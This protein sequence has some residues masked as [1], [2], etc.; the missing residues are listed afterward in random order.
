MESTS[1]KSKP[2]DMKTSAPSPDPWM[3]GLWKILSCACFAAI[4]GMVRYLSGGVPHL[5]IDPLPFYEIAFLQN[6]IGALFMLPW[7]F[8]VSGGTFRTTMPG[9]HILR[10]LFA[11]TGLLLWYGALHVMPLAQ[12]VAL[13]FTGPIFSIIGCRLFLKEAL[14]LP[15][16]S[17]IL[18]SLIGGFVITRP[19]QALL[20]GNGLIA[21]IGVLACL[22]LFAAIAWVGSKLVA[23]HMA[24]QGESASL[25]T[26]YLLL[27]M[28]PIS[29]IPAL[30]VWQTPSLEQMGWVTA[31]GITAS[32]AHL[33]LAR[34][35]AHA[36]VS[37]LMPFGLSRL[38]LSGIIGYFAFGEIPKSVGIWLGMGIIVLSLILLSYDSRYKFKKKIKHT[39]IEV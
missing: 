31:I 13:V 17:A 6:V 29:A 35:F 18:V 21:E 30:S 8:K 11:V 1:A 7:I 28:A 38:V 26:T 36:D 37:F 25:M 20:N 39:P 12:A 32:C 3:G 14:T 10:V 9:F 22:P 16:L 5:S 19:D 23:R 33:T 27:F 15:R 34:A 24:S 4:N 2:Y